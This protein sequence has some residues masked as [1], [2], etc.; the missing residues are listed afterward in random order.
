MAPCALRGAG[1]HG[2]LSTVLEPALSARWCT[3]C[4]GAQIE[5]RAGGVGDSGERLNGQ[6]DDMKHIK[7]R[8]KKNKN[9]N[10]KRSS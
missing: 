2:E 7:Y 6:M 9:V 8:R 4:T 5:E 1:T 10:D 3:P